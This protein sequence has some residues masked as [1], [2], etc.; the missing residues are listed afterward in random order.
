[1]ADAVVLVED[2]ITDEQRSAVIAPLGEFSAVRG[3]RFSPS[4]IYLL[5]REGDRIVGGLLGHSNWDWLYIEV[6]SV[7]AHLRSH[8]FGR[9][10]VEKAEEI[11][12]VRGCVGVWV[13]TY[14]FQSPG[15][16]E[17]LGYRAFGTLPN[18]PGTEQRIFLMK[19]L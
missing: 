9:R 5:L 12:R 7:A 14:T 15:F 11:A 3:F 16:Y 13:D 10:L 17:C 18:Y 19:M 8:G 2:Q 6:L 4:P 1:M